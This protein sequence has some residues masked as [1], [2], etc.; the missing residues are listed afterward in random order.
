MG[1]IGEPD[2]ASVLWKRVLTNPELKDEKK[3]GFERRPNQK[4]M[5]S[6][7]KKVENQG[8]SIVE[9]RRN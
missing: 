4:K 8:K 9:R 7:N 1:C 3:S 6:W 5:Q 2:V